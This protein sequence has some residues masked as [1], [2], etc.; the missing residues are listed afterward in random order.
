[1]RLA[2]LFALTFFAVAACKDGGTEEETP[3]K[4]STKKAEPDVPCQTS[5]D[6]ADVAEK[7]YCSEV[8]SPLPAGW[9][10]GV[11]DGTSASVGFTVVLDPGSPRT[12]TDLAFNP[13]IPDQL[14]VVNAKDDSVFIVDRPGA[15]DAA[16]QRLRDPAASHFMDRPPAIAFGAVVEPWGQTFGVCGDSD[17]GGNKFM[18]PALFSSDLSI[19][20]LETGTGLGSHLDM[21]HSTS[22]CR[23]IAHVEGNVY[24]A[25]NSDKGSLDKY[26]FVV[27]HGPGQDDHSDGRIW[28]YVEGQV[29]GVD[30]VPSHLAYDADT[31]LLY[32]ADTGN[33]RVAVLDTQSGSEGATFSGDEP[34][35]RR[36]VDGAVLSDF[37]PAGTLQ[38]PSG[39]EL[40]DGVVFVSDEATSV[41]YAFDEEGALIRTLE[42]G[43]PPGSLAGITLGITDQKLYF[44]D[45]PKSVVYR[46]DPIF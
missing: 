19:F 18:G 37:V 31:K 9:Q 16:F 4:K 5:A 27:D 43:L 41:L 2:S 12:S 44:V 46:I 36:H 42:T 22:F 45:K 23:G 25:F 28:R 6:C 21:L 38:R 3:K 26:D 10:I 30:G 24:F 33:Q 40:A 11:G 15:P 8:C 17:N 35:A 20:T 39:I 13:S 7:P 29:S 32:V 1:M 34:A 14:W